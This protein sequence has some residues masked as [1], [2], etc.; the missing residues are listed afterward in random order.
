MYDIC[1][2]YLESKLHPFQECVA[3]YTRVR[4]RVCLF[5]YMRA[6]V[7][8]RVLFCACMQVERK[9]PRGR[10]PRRLRDEV[11]DY[12]KGTIWQRTAQDRQ[13]SKQHAE[14][15]AQPRDAMAA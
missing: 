2:I 14:A 13:M 4:V 9:R 5:V 11:D 8:A 6:G 12:W 3:T 10:P 7:C 15:F 1:L